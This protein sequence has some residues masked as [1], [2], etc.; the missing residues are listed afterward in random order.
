MKFFEKFCKIC[1]KG[2][3]E[4]EYYCICIIF[5]YCFWYVCYNLFCIEK[6]EK[7]E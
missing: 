1:K 4:F 6:N 2:G 5:N 7:C 3:V